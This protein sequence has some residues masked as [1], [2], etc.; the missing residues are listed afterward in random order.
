LTATI[1]QRRCRPDSRRGVQFFLGNLDCASTSITLTAAHH[2]VLAEQ[3]WVPSDEDQSIARIGAPEH[4]EL[5]VN[6]EARL[7]IILDLDRF[8][9]TQSHQPKEVDMA[10]GKEK[11]SKQLD[12]SSV[13]A[14]TGRNEDEEQGTEPTEFAYSPSARAAI[15][16]ANEAFAPIIEAVEALENIEAWVPPVVKGVRALRDRAMRETG[17]LT[18]LDQ[19]YRTR[20]GDLLNAEPIGPWLLDERRRSLLDAVHYLGSDDTY[21]DSF[22]E[23]R[24]ARITDEQ[25]NKWRKLR[26]LVDHFKQWQRGSVPD[27]DRRTPDQKEIEAVRTEGHKADA[28]LVAQVEQARREVATHV[29]ESTD[30]L[31]AILHKA[32]PQRFVE[33]LQDHDAKDY[34][35]AVYKLLGP[36]LKEPAG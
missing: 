4:R 27:R 22:M 18:Y 32:G 13:R 10:L 2:V 33:S 36:W 8:K 15:D 35:L 5:V 9:E 24:R 29:I 23:W 14:D 26:T 19:Q 30:T 28:A 11:L 31:W 7:T 16:G 17:A 25:R 20:F 3:S 6:L 12:G 34:A 21:L 1:C